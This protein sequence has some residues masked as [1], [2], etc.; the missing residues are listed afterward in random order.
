MWHK[1]GTRA[2]VRAPEGEYAGAVEADLDT[3]EETEEKR[4]A[5][6]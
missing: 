6:G 2:S 5:T 4:T 3:G 1:D